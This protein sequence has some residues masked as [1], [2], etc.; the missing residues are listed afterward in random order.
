M[1]QEQRSIAAALSAADFKFRFQIS[2]LGVQRTCSVTIHAVSMHDAA[3]IFRTN[4]PTIESLARRSIA[5]DDRGD[6]RLET[7]SCG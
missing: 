2:S 5:A 3:A 4:W 6:I 7:A 1:R